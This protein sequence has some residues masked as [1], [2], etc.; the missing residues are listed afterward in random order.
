MSQL[1]YVGLSRGFILE[2]GPIDVWV[3]SASD[4]IRVRG[5]FEVLG[6]AIDLH[7]RRTYLSTAFERV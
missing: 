5:R 6:D 4:D 2:P 7:G 1:G 3:G